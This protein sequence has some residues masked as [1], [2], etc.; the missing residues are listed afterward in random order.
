MRRSMGLATSPESAGHNPVRQRRSGI[1]L[2]RTRSGLG[3][4]MQAHGE[5]EQR[6][7]AGFSA[8]A[9]QIVIIAWAVAEIIGREYCVISYQS[10]IVK[11]LKNVIEDHGVR[12]R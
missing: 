12:L 11:E 1:L 9:A 10:C 8:G 3:K 6:S 5:F 4:I 7:Q 2:V